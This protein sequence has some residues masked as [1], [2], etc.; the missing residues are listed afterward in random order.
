MKY[1]KFLLRVFGNMGVSFFGPLTGTTIAESIYNINISFEQQLVI[2]AVASIFTT[3]LVLS[4]EAERLG[5]KR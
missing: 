5:K 2:A 1:K 4:R 3:G